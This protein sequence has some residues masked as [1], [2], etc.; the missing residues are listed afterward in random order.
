VNICL[1]SFI[2]LLAYSVYVIKL[3]MLQPQNELAFLQ[4]TEQNR[5]ETIKSK[6]L[7]AR[8]FLLKKY[9]YFLFSLCFL[10]GIFSFSFK[11][12]LEPLLKSSVRHY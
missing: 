2:Y 1:R 11:E 3:K 4:Q 9:Y 5:Q 12:K 7:K 8:S 10:I 6:F